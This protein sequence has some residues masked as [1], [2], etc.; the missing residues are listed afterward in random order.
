MERHEVAQ[1][2]RTLLSRIA[3][4]LIQIQGLGR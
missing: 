2:V 3:G 4:F 1:Q